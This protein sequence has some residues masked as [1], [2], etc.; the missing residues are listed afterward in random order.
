MSSGAELGGKTKKVLIISVGNPLRSDDGLGW[1]VAEELAQSVHSSALEIVT[2]F[3]LTP[4]LAENM[5]YAQGVLFID[6]CRDG[7]PGELKFAPV[8]PG[9]GSFNSHHLSPAALLQLASEL[10]G[11]IPPAL[12]ASICG[13]CF[14]LGETL[15]PKVAAGLSRLTSRVI[16]ATK[17]M[18]T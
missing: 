18:C 2:R 7:E 12:I 6:A 17:Q 8:I 5:H 16:Q 1:R 9:D 4:E 13:E 3:Q 14:E 15:S 11:S 10:Y